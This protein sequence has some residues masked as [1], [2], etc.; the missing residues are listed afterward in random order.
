MNEIKYNRIQ[1]TLFEF[2]IDQL[3]LAKILKVNKNS[4]SRWCRNLVQPSLYQLR[5][6]A[7]FFGIDVR[8]L[9]EPT[10]WTDRKG[11]APVENYKETR[12]ETKEKLAA[13][14]K[15]KLVKKRAAKKVRRKY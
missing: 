12:K 2:D 6:I 10:T 1:V 8:Q 3:E 4:V 14:N 15:K 11:P 7:E 5:D 13:A 9:I